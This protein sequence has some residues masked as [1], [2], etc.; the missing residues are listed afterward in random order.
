[1]SSSGASNALLP[2]SR[3]GSI[4]DRR[5]AAAI[6][7][8]GVTRV[9]G[10][11]PALVRVTLTVDRGETLLVRGPNGAGKSTLLRVMGTALSPTYGGGSVLGFDL[12]RER[13][14]IRRRTE[15]LGHRTRLYED[16]SARENLRFACV[17]YGID[18]DGIGAVLE[19]VGLLDVA[20]ERVRAFSQGMRQRVA[21]ARALMREPELLLLDEP[22]AGLDADAKEVVDEAITAARADGR[23]VV[24]ATHDPT[25]GA[26]ADRTVHMEQ[27][28]MLPG[29]PARRS[30]RDQVTAG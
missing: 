21:V 5:G 18:Q 16:L 24:L 6:E 27:G 13:D 15:L 8:S 20:G 2:A 10:M 11:S 28:R 23:T 7:L 12:S 26:I 29:E 1:M 22:Y 9:F 14:E 19:R 30:G 17:L 4:P 3:P 25:R